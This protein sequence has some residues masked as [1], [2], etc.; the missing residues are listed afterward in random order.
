MQITQITV[1]KV[2]T[3]P[4]TFKCTKDR[5]LKLTHTLCALPISLS[6]LSP[7]SHNQP[8]SIQR[9]EECR[10]YLALPFRF[11]SFI[12]EPFVFTSI[13]YIQEGFFI[14]WCTMR[15]CRIW[16][17]TSKKGMW[18]QIGEHCC[19][20]AHYVVDIHRVEWVK[21][22][23]T[24]YWLGIF[25][26]GLHWFLCLY[27]CANTSKNIVYIVQQTHVQP[28]DFVWTNCASESNV[29][30][31]RTAGFR[32]NGFMAFSVSDASES[33]Q[34]ETLCNIWLRYIR[35]SQYFL[36]TQMKHNN[37]HCY[38][39]RQFKLNYFTPRLLQ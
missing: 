21:C 6:H 39:I 19:D 2:K 31:F 13:P 26:V 11:Y 5:A 1:P 4:K 34:N 8:S 24:V 36:F 27:V 35:N 38:L 12:S 37:I 32:G 18:N 3:R 9:S 15:A 28:I 22:E 30:F 10:L 17:S 20:H 7:I 16:L 23:R 14:F 25:M 33:T 29:F